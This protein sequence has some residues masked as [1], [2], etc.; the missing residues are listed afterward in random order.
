MNLA[1]VQAVIDS[2]KARGRGSLHRYIRERMPEAEVEEAGDVAMEIIDSVP[3]FLARARQAATDRKV[4]PMVVPILERAAGYF[5]SPMDLI[6]EMTLG[7]AGLLDDAYLV[8][9]VLKNLDRGPDPL[10][11]W[12]LDEPIDFLRGLVGSEVSEKLDLFSL[13]SMEAA[14]L[15]FQEFWNRMAAEA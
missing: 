7:L 8:L 5:L 11:E 14:E 3:V 1:D 2:A 9:R 6:P 10:L 4:Q 13:R 12:E 15:Q